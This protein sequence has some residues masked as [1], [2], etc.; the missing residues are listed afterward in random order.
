M[1]GEELLTLAFSIVAA[2]QIQVKQLDLEYCTDGEFH[3]VY[4]GVL[5][6]Q[7]LATLRSLIFRPQKE[8]AL[9]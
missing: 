2:T 7:S 8:Y 5:L 3:R 1:K 6:A 9:I 4:N